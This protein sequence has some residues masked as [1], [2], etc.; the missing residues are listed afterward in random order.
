M[1][2]TIDYYQRLADKARS[3]AAEAS[4][5]NVRQ[6]F[7]LSAERFDEMIARIHSIAQAKSRNE[8][9]K[10]DDRSA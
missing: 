10:R 1:T 2:D 8:A 5:P 7:L 4:L 3:D 6:R 9:A